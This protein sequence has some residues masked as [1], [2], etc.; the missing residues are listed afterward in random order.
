MEFEELPVE[1]QLWIIARLWPRDLLSLS[2]VS[3]VYCQLAN[4]P[5]IWKILCAEELFL[6][7]DTLTEGGD[8]SKRYSSNWKR[9]YYS[10][11]DLLPDNLIGVGLAPGLSVSGCEAS[12]VNAIGGNQV[13]FGNRPLY[14]TNEFPI[15]RALPFSEKGKIKYEMSR[16]CIGYYEVTILK[17]PPEVAPVHSFPHGLTPCVAVGLGRENFPNEGYL[18]GWKM[19]SFGFHSDDGKVYYNSVSRTYAG[20][21]GRGDTIGCGVNKEMNH[22]FFTKNGKHLGIACS[23]ESE[24]LFPIIGLDAHVTVRVNFGHREP[25]LYDFSPYHSQEVDDKLRAIFRKRTALLSLFYPPGIEDLLDSGSSCAMSDDD[26]SSE[27]S[28]DESSDAGDSHD[29]MD[30]EAND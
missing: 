22:I 6:D 4:D 19:G 21:F 18:P 30:D 8:F 9:V 11:N 23:I 1:V 17:T 24:R 27:E 5:N 13:V 26:E 29:A 3:R 15:V 14:P 2:Q 12:F 10:I 16:T 28:D 25:F 20:T 7:P